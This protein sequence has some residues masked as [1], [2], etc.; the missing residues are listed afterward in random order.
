MA[1]GVVLGHHRGVT[2]LGDLLGLL[3]LVRASLEF[4]QVDV[5]AHGLLDL[6]RDLGVILKPA[7]EGGAGLRLE[8]RNV[9]LARVRL[10]V[11]GEGVDGHGCLLS[12]RPDRDEEVGPPT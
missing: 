6:A 2:L 12:C 3:G 4:L 7:F 9:V 10:G 11:L 8:V 1:A 5:G